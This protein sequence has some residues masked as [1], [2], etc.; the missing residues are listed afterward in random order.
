MID[1]KKTQIDC[2][3]S[4][5]SVFKQQVKIV[6]CANK[7]FSS[8]QNGGKL[9]WVG[10]G[11]SAAE[12]QHMSAEYMVRYKK[13]RGPLASIALTADTCLLTAHTNDFDYETVFSRQIEALANANDIL[14]AISTSGNSKNWLNAILQ[15]R[16]M[17]LTVIVLT[18]PDTDLSESLFDYCFNIESDVTARIQEGHTLINHLICEAVET[19]VS[20]SNDIAASD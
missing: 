20:Q 12:C 3:A 18:G 5:E 8:L 13:N 9:M 17:E 10:N 16:E 1:W 7:I 14:F 19:L 15:A 2:R 6:E 11:G 4:Q